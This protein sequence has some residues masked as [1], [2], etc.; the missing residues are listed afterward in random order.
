MELSIRRPIPP[1]FIGGKIYFADNDGNILNAKGRKRKPQFS[2]A[3]RTYKGGS[4][5]PHVKIGGRNYNVHILVCTA[6]WGPRPKDKKGND[7]E[8]HHLNGNKFDTRPANL[9]WLSRKEHLRFDAALR[10]GLI[11]VHRDT[12]DLMLHDMTHHCEI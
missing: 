11:L 1:K 5:Y 9:I 7:F 4:C 6:F 3:N 10:K 12:A 2:P 8:C